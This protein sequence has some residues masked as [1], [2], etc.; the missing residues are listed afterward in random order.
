MEKRTHKMEQAG[1]S[2]PGILEKNHLLMPYKLYQAKL[3]WSQIAGQQIA[4]YSYIRDYDGHEVIIAVLNPVWMSHLFIYK[5]KLIDGI[6]SF[7]GQPFIRDARFVRSG[8]KPVRI[9]YENVNGETENVYPKGN[10]KNIVLPKDMVVM[11]RQETAYLPEAL[12]E[13]MA[14]LRFAQM[15]RQL[16]YGDEGFKACPRCGRWLSK[17]ETLCYICRLQERQEKKKAVRQILEE[18]PWLTL[19]DM[20]E[21]GYIQEASGIG[22][23]LYN[24]VRRDCIYRLLEKIHNGYDTEADDFCLAMFIT[25]KDPKMLTDKFIHNLTEKYRRKNDV[26]AYRR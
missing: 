12:R 23:E 24:E 17:G 15:R 4:K 7:I 26:S 6:N 9:V 21:D 14:Q 1:L 2:I 11:I 13:K 5:Q 19:E 20:V 16:A 22:A 10:L 25:R 8:K 18:M 3:D